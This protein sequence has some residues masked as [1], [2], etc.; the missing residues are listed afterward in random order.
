M[1]NESNK[2]DT[3]AKNPLKKQAVSCFES[4]HRQQLTAEKEHCHTC[5]D[6]PQPQCH[7]DR[8][9]AESSFLLLSSSVPRSNEQPTEIRDSEFFEKGFNAK[10]TKR[11]MQRKGS[12]GLRLFQGHNRSLVGLSAI[13]IH[14]GIFQISSPFNFFV[15]ICKRRNRTNQ[16]ILDNKSVNTP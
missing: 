13:S 6:E 14:C 15:R 7:L 5:S 16:S 9:S 4:F 8:V 12:L 11:E 1:H 10:N 3:N 2:P